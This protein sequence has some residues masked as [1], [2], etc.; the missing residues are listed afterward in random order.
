MKKKIILFYKRLENIGGA[1]N[2]LIKEYEFFSKNYDCYIIT[3]ENKILKKDFKVL[4]VSNIFYLIVKI[5]LINP[6]VI[7]CSS[8][9]VDIHIATFIQLKK[10]YTHIHQPSLMSF[11][12]TDKFTFKNLEKLKAKFSSN[13]AIIK[14]INL[15]IWIRKRLSFKKKI[16]IYLRYFISK[17]AIKRSKGIF[18]LSEYAMEE[19]KILYDIQ[20]IYSL[21]GAIENSNLI[22]S[23]KDKEKDK[24][25]LIIIS[26][27]DINKR[28]S[29]VIRSLNLSSN[30]NIILDIYGKGKY[31]E[32]LKKLIKVLD[33]E[34]KVFLKGFLNENLKFNT[35]SSYD[36]F[37]CLD[38]ADF[39]LS[40]FESLKCKTP[41]ILTTE[42]FPNPG[43]DSLKC[44]IYSN[45]DI[46]S[47]K[48]IFDCL[49]KDEQ[50][51][52]NWDQLKTS[53]EKLEWSNYFRKIDEI[54]NS[55]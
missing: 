9:Y 14:N 39:R 19:K 51:K 48:I 22:N 28:I 17:W 10:F 15:F 44:L 23:S 50:N 38:M 37:L 13:K 8:G 27:L 12:E 35:I 29:K 6:S 47:L 33:L 30:K 5:F 11:N 32:Y 36:Y 24:I 52:I 4:E 1:E 16:R 45:P 55:N 25:K 2:L 53:L 41:V 54:I 20:N 26:R 46:K 34:K 3:Y 21:R 42:S 7:I 49:N 43:F 18:V 40:C 31:E